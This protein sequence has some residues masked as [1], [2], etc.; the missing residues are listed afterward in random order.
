MQLLASGRDSE[1]YLYG[2]GLV[3]RRYRDG[4]SAEAEAATIR[5]VA[6]LGYPVPEVQMAT[7]ADI[8]MERVDGPTMV[9]AILDG[10]SP[11]SA[12]ATL[13]GL[14]DRLHA[15]NWP[16][17]NPGES[18]LHLD[19]HPMNV[20]MHES[21]PVVIDWSNARTGPAAMDVATT[22]LILAQVVVTDGM[23]VSEGIEE[24]DRLRSALA[25]V[26]REF[27]RCVNTP[28][29]GYLSAAEAYRRQDA[30]QSAAELVALP[31]ALNLAAS[32]S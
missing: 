18:L 20:L 28:Y 31:V 12:G 8:V 1:V 27:A 17:A 30:H 3:L 16:G 11:E 6:S 5:A 13:A 29:A 23:L 22:A 7:G 10:L 19:L 25:G 2:E 14:H 4:R 21:T 26:L 15:L 9:N 24:D 32:V